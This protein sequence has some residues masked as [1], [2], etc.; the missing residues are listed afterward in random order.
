MVDYLLS[1]GRTSVNVFA[2]LVVLNGAVILPFYV[3]YVVFKRKRKQGHD[4]MSADRAGLKAMGLVVLVMVIAIIA[5]TL[6][7]NT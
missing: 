3:Q 2:F 1:F 6:W 5:A 4:Y 7:S